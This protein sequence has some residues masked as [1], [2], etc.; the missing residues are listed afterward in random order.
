[1]H[2]YVSLF[3]SSRA[4]VNDSGSTIMEKSNSWAGPAPPVPAAPPNLIIKVIIFQSDCLCHC[5]DWFGNCFALFY[6]Q[7]FLDYFIGAKSCM[8]KNFSD[9]YNYCIIIFRDKIV[10]IIM[11]MMLICCLYV[12][13][14]VVF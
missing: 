11:F 6:S 4:I 3:I 13:Y 5:N 10:Q 8:S 12:L 14:I 2:I 1:M 9:A 7:I